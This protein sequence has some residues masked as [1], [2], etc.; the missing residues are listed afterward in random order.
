MRAPRAASWRSTGWCGAGCVRAAGRRHRRRHR[1][2]RHGGGL[3]LAGARRSPATSIRWRPRRRARTWPPTDSAA[4]SRCV[5]AAGFAHPRLHAAAPFDLIFANILAAP[6]KRLAPQIAAHQA[7][8]GVAIL[9]GILARQAAGVVAVYRGWGYRPERR[10]GSASGSTLV[11]R[12]R[13][14]PGSR[15]SRLRSAP[16]EVAGD[17]GDLAADAGR[18]RRAARRTA[19]A[20]PRSVARALLPGG[21]GVDSALDGGDDA[22]DGDGPEGQRARTDLRRRHFDLILG[23]AGDSGALGTP[24][25]ERRAPI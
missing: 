24:L 14:E 4:G 8:G 12:R 2:P 13:A 18:C 23:P 9:S 10:C 17:V 5:T 16:R 22:E 11:L 1:R 6:L 15:G 19:R 25:Y 21:D 20:A 3:G 7:P